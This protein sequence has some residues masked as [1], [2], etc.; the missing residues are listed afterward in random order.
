MQPVKFHSS[1]VP[2]PVQLRGIF[3]LNILFVPV[4]T[5]SVIAHRPFGRRATAAIYFVDICA[6]VHAASSLFL[7]LVHCRHLRHRARH[8]AL[9]F[10]C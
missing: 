3:L 7:L 4:D 8:L 2:F 9:C 6:T 1:K 10:F 5:S